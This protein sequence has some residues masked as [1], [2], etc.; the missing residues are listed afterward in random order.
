[1]EAEW[2]EET[3][4][5][6]TAENAALKQRVRQL[7]ADNRNLDERLKAAPS[8]LRFQ[9]RRVVDLEAQIAGT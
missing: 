5:R 8:N 7:A 3:I 1:M 6:I 2:T 9:D 4:Q